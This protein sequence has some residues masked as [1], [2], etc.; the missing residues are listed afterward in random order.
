MRR[1]QF[2]ALGLGMAA[3]LAGC[4]TATQPAH[5]PGRLTVVPAG[6]SLSRIAQAY[7]RALS[8]RGHAVTGLAGSTA[9]DIG[10]SGAT[11]TRI[12]VTSLPRLAA[13]EINGAPPIL[14]VATPLARLAGEP[15]AVVIPAN[16][17]FADF[18]ALAAQLVAD[19][20]RTYLA[21]GPQGETGHVLF[22]LIAQGL[23]ADTRL[24]DYAGYTGESEAAAS[25]MAGHACAA[26]GTL[27][28]WRPRIDRGRVKVIAVS[29]DERVPGID[30]PTLKECGVRVD[31]AEW[32][33]AFGP[34]KLAGR[35]REAMAAA[36]DEAAYSDDWL[37]ACRSGGWTP[38]PLSGD[39]FTVWLTSELD[40]TR[41]VLRDLGLLDT[42][43]TT[44]RG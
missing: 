29:T 18:D 17:R 9:A 42:R 40:R 21:G 12:T 6:E 34:R 15:V 16:S 3:S 43:G 36:C 26:A 1:R 24:V 25:L 28:A 37:E 39:D 13:A 20:A 27:A 4:A 22:G 35:T 30:A 38:M 41:K 19:P 10:A 11:V 14:E 44:Y 7:G 23:G 8:R 32:C 2:F 33:A 5:G 31:F